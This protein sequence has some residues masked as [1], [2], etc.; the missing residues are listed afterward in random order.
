M[1]HIIA[2][3][4]LLT[5]AA[6]A[7][8]FDT[9][10]AASPDNK[11][12]AVERR[13]PNPS[14]PS[15]LDVNSFV[16]LIY[17]GLAHSSSGLAGQGPV[18]ARHTFGDRIVSQIGWSPDSKFLLFTTTSSGDHS[19]RHFRTFAFSVADKSFRD[20]E[21]AIGAPVAAGK[22][23]FEYPDVA[24]LSL[25]DPQHEHPKEIKLPLNKLVQHMLRLE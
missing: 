25:Y 13:V 12:F 4:V 24:V 2:L 6:H 17:T 3:T 14:E 21:T 1:K 15:R 7:E 9:W 16:V 22:F 8:N 23:R 20:V 19:L 11:F 10:R 18:I 5:T